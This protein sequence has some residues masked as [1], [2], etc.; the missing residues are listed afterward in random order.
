MRV[1]MF[2]RTVAQ[3][4][5]GGVEDHINMLCQGLSKE[6]IEVEV[7]TTSHP[8][9][10]VYEEINGVKYHYVPGSQPKR[11]SRQ[12][13]KNSAKKFLELHLK[14]PFDIVHSQSAG[15]LGFV[16]DSQCSSLKL[17]FVTSLHGT[18]YDEIQTQLNKLKNLLEVRT[19]SDFFDTLKIFPKLL[20]QLYNYF[21]LDPKYLSKSDIIIATSNE[22]KKILIETFALDTK[23]IRLV[24]N[25]VD[26]NLFSPLP[27][28]L[29]VQKTDLLGSPVLLCVARLERE[30]GV[31]NAI[32]GL[33]SIIKEYPT[34]L[35]VVVGDG[36]YRP[37][38]ESL[39]RDL[40]INHNVKFTGFVP[41]E[42]LP[43]YFSSCDIFL[44]PTI[45][46]NGYDLTVLEAM[47]C[48]RPV[49]A[50]NIGSMP[51]A[52]SNG[53]DGILIKPGSASDLA[54]AVLDLLKNKEKADK[55]GK[56]ARQKVL[57]LFS[58]KSMVSSTV[59]IYKDALAQVR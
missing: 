23:K 21:F 25:A 54:L 48:E 20:F 4:G 30:K 15:G 51:T 46:Q 22:Q 56:N 8:N 52:I 50:S 12:W 31:Q 43:Y 11:Y 16:L 5:K 40:N 26:E 13:W 17:P 3:Q 47:S 18:T 7:I 1:C 37:R 59:A 34:A 58:L 24:Y 45:R 2:T 27:R 38:L 39:A 29:A 44:N 57:S 55:I 9:S 49:I 19:I 36:S 33:H 6:G 42:S 41:Y 10:L 14:E 35:L 53:I 28:H 32:M